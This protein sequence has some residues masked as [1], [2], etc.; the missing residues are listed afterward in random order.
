MS[1]YLLHCLEKAR[2][3]AVSRLV[4]DDEPTAWSFEQVRDEF[5]SC[6]PAAI[7]SSASDWRATEAC[8]LFVVP[9]RGRGR[10]V[11][12]TL[13]DVRKAGAAK[14]QWL[15][16]YGLDW[17]D[18]QIRPVT[19][20]LEWACGQVDHYWMR[21]RLGPIEKRLRRWFPPNVAGKL[22][23][24]L[25]L[26]K[27]GALVPQRFRRR[28]VR[29]QLIGWFGFHSSGDDLIAW[30]IRKVFEARAEKQ[31]LRMLWTQG[32]EPCDLGV[33]GGG[34]I[35]GCDTS[36][37]CERADAITA[38]L[39]ILGPGFRNTG[40]EEC[41]RWRPRMQAL[42][43]RAIAAGVRGPHTAAAL[44]RY[45]MVDS[46]PVVGDAAVWFEPIPVSPVIPGPTVGIC[47]R[48]MKN[49]AFEERYA[50]GD[51]TSRRF[52]SLVPLVLERLQARPVFLSFAEN[53][54]DS[55]SEGAE[56]LRAL[57]PQPYQ[58]APVVHYSPD[59]RHNFSL[60]GQFDY[61]ISERMHP[62]IVAW[63]LGKPCIMID[64]QYGK[65]CD[66]M[67]GIDMERFCVRTDELTV[68]S[69][70]PRF[71]ELLHRRPE[72]AAAASQRFAHQRL[73]QAELV[74]RAMDSVMRRRAR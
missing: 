38:P 29:A 13:A 6:F 65:G 52:A 71:E 67:A 55:D 20:R 40:E 56:R 3:S 23:T 48:Q 30:C 18:I 74:D 7:I 31:Q 51:E 57:L 45:G 25:F 22:A 59:V 46:V 58:D 33:I 1:I 64:N 69:Y 68:E 72:L 8:D 15:M 54:F 43:D 47:I 34:T 42:F 63:L 49:T 24:T 62:S 16:L 37:I 2:I 36:R 60:V 11:S 26:G 66:F 17:R 21:D 73:C 12:R 32:D 50:P 70:L 9:F 28:T 41:R 27:V 4:I 39:A 14:A 35:I 10:G 61:L 19:A 44:G 53:D 5:A